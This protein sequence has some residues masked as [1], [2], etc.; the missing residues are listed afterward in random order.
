MSSS[1]EPRGSGSEPFCA[2]P[3]AGA[4]GGLPSRSPSHSD[5][6]H[7]SGSATASGSPQPPVASTPA[8]PEAPKSPQQK[9]PCAS[10]STA[11]SPSSR[12]RPTVVSGSSASSRSSSAN[13]SRRNTPARIGEP[14]AALGESARRRL[15]LG[16][17]ALPGGGFVRAPDPDRQRAARLEAAHAARAAWAE[18][19][20]QPRPPSRP[21]EAA[22][23]AEPIVLEISSDDEEYA[24]RSA[25]SGSPASASSSPAI[26][27]AVARAERPVFGATADART[28]DYASATDR[29]RERHRAARATRDGSV[30][31]DESDGVIDLSVSTQATPAQRTITKYRLRN[32]KLTMPQ[33]SPPRT[34]PPP[35]EHPLASTFTCPICLC[36]PAKASIT[37]CGHVFCGGCL[38]D[39]LKAQ[40]R[41]RE[42]NNAAATVGPQGWGMGLFGA[43]A[44]VGGAFGGAGGGGGGEDGGGAAGGDAAAGLGGGRAGGGRG[45]GRGGQRDP[46][47]GHCPVCRADIKG[48]FGGIAKGGIVGVRLMVGKPV[49]D[50]RMEDGQL[51]G[52]GAGGGEEEDK[53]S[54][55]SEIEPVSPQHVAA[56]TEAPGMAGLGDLG[57]GSSRASGKRKRVAD[58]QSS[59]GEGGGEVSVLNTP[60]KMRKRNDGAVDAA[61][62]DQVDADGEEVI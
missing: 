54:S 25:T 44:M 62:G 12:S 37:P 42:A 26:S 41:Q 11:A 10:A 61:E 32:S 24:P 14:A 30:S 3:G 9:D 17:I 51:K 58:I 18:R 38:F 6:N 49:D 15:P 35:I 57:S 13:S 28:G 59:L 39:A 29:D 47:A 21:R 22:G 40:A 5:G 52:G 4:G 55:E 7:K 53:T 1:T 33:R 50:P 56:G 34:K 8:F 36:P 60:S 2:H 31:S 46:L 45:R 43:A 16:G 27:R 23:G 20:A 19:A 48:A